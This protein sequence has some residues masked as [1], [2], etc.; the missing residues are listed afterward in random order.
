MTLLRRKVFWNP[1]IEKNIKKNQKQH[2]Y[3][4]YMTPCAACP[5][6]LLTLQI[7]LLDVKLYF[8]KLSAF[9]YV[10]ETNNDFKNFQKF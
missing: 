9:I 3:L 6:K 4:E 1:K 10:Y 5:Q 8:W 7:V 2:T